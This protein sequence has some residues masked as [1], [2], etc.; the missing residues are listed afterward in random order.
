M[1][2]IMVMSS[3]AAQALRVEGVGVVYLVMYTVC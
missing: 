3:Q 1:T 2:L